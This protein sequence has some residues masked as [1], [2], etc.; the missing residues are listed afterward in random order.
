MESREVHAS[1]GRE[2]ANAPAAQVAHHP[3]R[4]PEDEIR[5]A[6]GRLGARRFFEDRVE[7]AE[8]SGSANALEEIGVGREDDVPPL[9]RDL[10][11]VAEAAR[12]RQPR[13][14]RGRVPGGRERHVVAPQGPDCSQFQEATDA[15]V[16]AQVREK[17]G[18]A[19]RV[20]AGAEF[21]FAWLRGVD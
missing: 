15:A 7:D 20:H 4:I 12:E 14:A 1:R 19:E 13:L 2:G 5:G 6:P 18:D 8:R 10:L 3:G 21:T 11:D 17:D 16:D 9:L